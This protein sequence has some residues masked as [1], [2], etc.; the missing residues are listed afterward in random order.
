L[1]ASKKKCSGISTSA[2]NKLAGV[3][4]ALYAKYNHHDFIGEDP[5]QFVYKYDNHADMEVAGFF[6]AA[7][8]YGRV[9]QISKSL[10]KLFSI[11]GDSPADFVSGFCAKDRRRLKGFKHRFNTGDDISDLTVLLKHVINKHGSIEG[12]FLKGY[13][14]SDENILPALTGFCD[15]LLGM[16]ANRHG[17]EVGRG[18]MYLLA[19]PSRKSACKRLNLFLRWMVRDDD[20]DAGLW[21]SICPSKL[22]VPVDVHM[23]RLCEIIGFHSS[24]NVSLKT[25]V[26][27]SRNFAIISPDDPV[28]YDFALSRIGIIEN[29]NGKINDNCPQCELYKYC[30]NRKKS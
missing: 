10:E 15:G 1:K 30:I 21:K 23:A 28:R 25:A 16:H 12:Y 11:M 27:I 3:L 20:V 14:D 17:G 13:S 19:S 5:L 2:Q 24:K 9:R 29:C 22:I 6:S 4:E 18:L 7:L 8:A 26:E